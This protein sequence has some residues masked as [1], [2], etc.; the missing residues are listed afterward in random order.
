MIK[1]K[2]EKILYRDIA[3]KTKDLLNM[4]MLIHQKIEQVF[5]R[6]SLWTKI[7]PQKIFSDLVTFNSQANGIN[8]KTESG[9]Q[10]IL[11]YRSNSI[12]GLE[13]YLSSA[14]MNA[15]RIKTQTLMPAL[16]GM[17]GA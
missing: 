8:P 7:M 12:D 11:G 4:R 2:D 5:E 15:P 1:G 3:F 17:R 6:A 13:S 16:Q 14:N 9:E 10:G